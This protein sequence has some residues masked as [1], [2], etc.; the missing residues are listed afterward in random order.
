MKKKYAI[1]YDPINVSSEL[2]NFTEVI[3]NNY[4]SKK[5]KT[6]MILIIG[7]N[8]SPKEIYEKLNLKFKYK[9]SFIIIEFDSFY[10]MFKIEAQDWITEH[11][12][13]MI[14]ADKENK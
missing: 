12:P 10:G 14:W 9:P 1:I 13:D 8:T 2:E 3:S 7:E 11:F 6:N 4:V 5:A